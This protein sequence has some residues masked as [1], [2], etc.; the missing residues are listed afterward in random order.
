MD[1]NGNVLA[2]TQNYEDFPT[3]DTWYMVYGKDT[4]NCTVSKEVWVEVDSCVSNI[5]EILSNKI[6]YK[7][8]NLWFG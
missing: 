3:E 2:Q 7:S 1:I 6:L 4:N 8:F 5:N